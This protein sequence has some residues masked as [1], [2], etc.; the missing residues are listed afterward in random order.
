VGLIEKADADM[1][2]KPFNKPKM[3][4]YEKTFSVSLNPPQSQ[5]RK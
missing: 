1:Y 4:V 2:E 3:Y 5:A